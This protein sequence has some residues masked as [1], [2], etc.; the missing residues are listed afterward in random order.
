MLANRQAAALARRANQR[1]LNPNEFPK[2]GSS[3]LT[4]QIIASQ[5]S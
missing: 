3:K 5:T 2:S 1:E 4:A